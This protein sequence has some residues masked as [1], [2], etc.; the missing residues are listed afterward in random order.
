MAI[1]SG[2]GTE[3]LKVNRYQGISTETLVFQGVANHIYTI[4][5]IIINQGDGVSSRELYLRL[6]DGTG[7]STEHYIIKALPVTAAGTF[8][9]N[10]KFVISGSYNMRLL[11]SSGDADIM[12]SYIDQ[13]WT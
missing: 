6:Y 9:F 8:V 11:S 1:P 2:S 12:V 7:T 10:D 5:S 4:L 13:D 3:V